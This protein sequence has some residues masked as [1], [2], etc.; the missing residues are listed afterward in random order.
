MGFSLYE[1]LCNARNESSASFATISPNLINENMCR[2]IMECRRHDGNSYLPSTLYG[3]VAGLQSYL[4]A[5][6]QHEIAFFS[7][8][9]PT[10]ARLRLTLDARMKQLTSAGVGSIKKQ[11]EPISEEHESILWNKDIFNLKTAQGFTYLTFFY[12]CKL[13]GL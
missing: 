4:R 2:F 13:F 9:D 3:L 6:G 12:N 7:S 11:A 1:A 8:T 5:E 10:F